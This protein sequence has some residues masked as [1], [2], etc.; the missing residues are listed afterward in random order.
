VVEDDVLAELK[1]IAARELELSVDLTPALR[2]HDDLQLDSMQMIIVAVGLEDHFAVKLE[3]EDVPAL[4]T[5]GDLCDLVAR[6]VR[7]QRASG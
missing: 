3:E 5:V 4:R 2:L 7:E 1:K 6:R